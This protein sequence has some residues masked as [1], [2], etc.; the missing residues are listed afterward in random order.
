MA[1]FTAIRHLLHSRRALTILLLIV[2]ATVVYQFFIPTL[3][4]TPASEAAGMQQLEQAK[5]TTSL[6]P[7]TSDGCSANVSSN[8]RAAIK[9]VSQ[10]SA[11]FATTYA[12]LATIPFESACIE[13]DQA[14][15]PGTGGYVGRLTADNQL[16]AAILTYGMTNSALIQTRT[17]LG[18]PA[19]AVYLYELL[20][21]AIYRGVRLG[22]APC[23]GEPY[24]W[25]FG[26]GGG[27]CE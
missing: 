22:G 21:E 2:V 4:F 19:E 9:K 3:T 5:R 23:T 27:S 6:E 16:R 15:H 17:G 13:H 1:M 10:H 24:A 14:Y 25:G 20:A 7:F 8:W 11:S 26:Y 12:D 18:S